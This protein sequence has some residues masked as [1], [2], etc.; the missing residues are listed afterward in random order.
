MLIRI[1]PLLTVA[2]LALLPTST[3]VSDLSAVPLLARSALRLRLYMCGVMDQIC[4]RISGRPA[5][6]PS[7]LSALAMLDVWGVHRLR[8]LGSSHG[9]ELVALLGTSP[10]QMGQDFLAALVLSK[11]RDGFFVEAGACD[12]VFSSNTLELEQRFGWTGI[13]CEPGRMWLDRLRANRRCTIDTHALWA[14]TGRQLSF[15]EATKPNLSTLT[16][17]IDGDMH[18]SER[19]T[20]S[21][22]Y[23]VE[24]ISLADLLLLHGAPTHIDFLSLDT[25]GSEQVILQDFP[26]DKYTFSVIAVEHNYAD[27]NAGLKG[28]LASRGYVLLAELEGVALGDHWFISR[29]VALLLSERGLRR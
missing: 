15:R 16:E 24:S 1:T 18:A 13:L 2:S 29:E 25:E 26:F 11:K 6:S 19:Q 9:R 28:L 17:F 22:E 23:S 21:I 12:G 8:L 20:S 4:L 7:A 10:S 27:S 14:E 5:I 3:Q